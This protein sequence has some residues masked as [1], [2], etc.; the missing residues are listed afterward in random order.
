MNSNFNN[1]KPT[2][3]ILVCCHKESYVPALDCYLPI[4]V[5]KA[6]AK[7]DLGFQ[8][9][10][11]GNNI[12]VKNPYYC[13]LTAIY[14]AWKNLRDIDYIGLCHYRRLFDFWFHPYIRKEAK[15]V[16]VEYV[17]SHKHILNPCKI[18][19]D[20]D[21]VLPTSIPFRI[22]IF[23]RHA[24][25]LNFIDFALLERIILDLYPE[26]R[27]SLKYIFYH[28]QDVPQRNMFVMKRDIFEHYCEFLF[29]ILFE[30]EKHLKLSPY[31]YYHRVCGFMGELLLPLFCYHNKLRIARRRILFITDEV[32]NSHLVFDIAKSCLNRLCFSLNELSRRPLYSIWKKDLLKREFSEINWDKL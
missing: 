2:V 12:S 17:E 5:G 22:N 28:S 30:V 1:N 18:I 14:W 9:D 13:E 19:V 16:S 8:G 32:K 20:K 21:V 31:N 15:N 6:N 29:S 7:I 3:K 24:L 27:D 11:T 25:N 4:Q 23:E 26:Y 10:D